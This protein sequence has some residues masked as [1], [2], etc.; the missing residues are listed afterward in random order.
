MELLI[1]NMIT[2]H[3]SKKTRGPASLQTVLI[4]VIFR[5]IAP[6]RRVACV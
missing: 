3:T 6:K 2:R 4:P 5:Y 1:L